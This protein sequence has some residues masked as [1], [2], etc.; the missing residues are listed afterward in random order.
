MTLLE[1]IWYQPRWFTIPLMIPLSPF[2]LLFWFVSGFRRWL[3][4]TGIKSSGKP[5]VPVIV[6]GN[7]SVGGNG[8]TPVVLELAKWL[9]QSGYRP[10]VLSRGYGGNSKSYPLCVERNSDPALVGDEPVLMKQHLSCPMVVDPERVRGANYLVDNCDCNL[11]LCDDGLQHYALERDIELIVMDGERRLGNGFL[12][13]MGPLREGA[14]RL[15][16]TSFIINNGGAAESGEY[17]MTLE[18]GKLINI[19]NPQV[20]MPLSEVSTSV[21]AAAAIGNPQRFFNYLIDKKLELKDCLSFPDHH[22]FKK[23]DLPLDRVIMTEKDAVKC[24]HNAHTDWWFLPVTANLP[25]AFKQKLLA[26]IES[27]GN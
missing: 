12:M 18:P 6:V 1:K 7:I 9:A 17:P 4:R 24:Q 11:I 3:Y 19:K 21:V 5:A 10:G 16:S 25:Q 14:W 15:S 13:P 23:G 27:V 20:S 22:Q 26:S 2:T 8:K